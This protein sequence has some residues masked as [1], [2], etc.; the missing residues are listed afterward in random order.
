MVFIGRKSNF[1]TNSTNDQRDKYLYK[2]RI[3]IILTKHRRTA[4]IKKTGNEYGGTRC[5]GKVILC[6]TEMG[7]DTEITLRAR[8]PKNWGSVPGSGR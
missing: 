2:D 1:V 5:K 7:A 6:L 8:L 3:A 4:I